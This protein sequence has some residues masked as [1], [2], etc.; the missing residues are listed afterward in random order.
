M[1]ETSLI[2]GLSFIYIFD[3]HRFKL[4]QQEI[5]FD[6]FPREFGG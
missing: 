2:S 3:Q 5:F 1:V 4:A 6:K